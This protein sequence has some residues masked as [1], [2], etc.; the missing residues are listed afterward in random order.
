MPHVILLGDSIFDNAAY[1]PGGPAVVEQLQA[2]L[3]GSW[4]ATLRAV[5]GS[6]A[7]D[8]RRQL[9]NLPADATHLVVST[10]GN[11]ALQSGGAVLGGSAASL[12]EALDQL[13]A[14][15]ADFQAE[16]RRMLQDVCELGMP[17]TVC[18]IYDAIPILGRVERAGLALFNEI[19]LAEA[20]LAGVPVVDLRWVCRE[21]ADFADLSPIEPSVAGGR[22]IAAAVARVVTSHDFS[23]RLCGLYV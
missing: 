18:T 6:I 1:V 12:A 11:N 3:P 7:A 23:R 14:V 22:R 15:R 17:T 8:V 16:Y 20:S 19:I 4:R 10:G 13:G 9:V 5:D 21:A 2:Q